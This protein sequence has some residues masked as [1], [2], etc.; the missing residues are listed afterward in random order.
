MGSGNPPTGGQGHSV[1]SLII[2]FQWDRVFFVLS[3]AFSWG[4]FSLFFIPLGQV[5]DLEEE[6]IPVFWIFWVEKKIQIHEKEVAP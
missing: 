5:L 4:D 3:K 1:G 6:K 2:G